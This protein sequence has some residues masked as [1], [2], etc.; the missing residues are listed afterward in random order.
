M[1]QKNKN[2]LIYV[3]SL[4]AS[5]AGVPVR[6][7]EN[8]NQIFSSVSVYLPIDPLSL[9]FDVILGC[10][11]EVGYV[12]SSTNCY[13]GY[14]N[15]PPYSIILGPSKETSFD[16]NKARSMLEAWT[17]SNDEKQLFLNELKSIKTMSLNA[18]A[19][20]LCLLEFSINGRKLAIEDIILQQKTQD[21]LSDKLSAQQAN[22][23]IDYVERDTHTMTY[24]AEQR[25]LEIVKNGDLKGFNDF[26][27]NYPAVQ[28]GTMSTNQI[29]QM[30]NIFINTATVVSR[31]AIQAGV[32]VDDALDLSDYYI[33][34]CELTSDISSISNLQYTMIVDYIKKIND[35]RER[36]LSL[37]SRKARNFIRNNLTSALTTGEVADHL[38]LS[39]PY[40]SALFKKEN[41][42]T[43][44]DYIASEKVK[45]ACHMLEYTDKS[46]LEISTALGFSSQSHFTKVFKKIKGVTPKSIRKEPR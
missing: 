14:V 21:E 31:T 2:D 24:I 3:C 9:D 43:L 11:Q 1:E 17:I 38:R 30:K 4:I 27:R 39:R 33:R 13:F 12:L 42:I 19:Q 20:V 32:D 6:V 26:V 45:E 15:S 29:R 35:T 40:L 7:F 41:G 34:Q 18:F 16:L 8:G 25:I 10:A 44:S 36:T 28:G 46:I 37:T 5:N 22:D 23:T